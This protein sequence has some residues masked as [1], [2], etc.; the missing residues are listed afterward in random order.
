MAGHNPFTDFIEQRRILGWTGRF[1]EFIEL[2]Y[3]N[4]LRVSMQQWFLVYKMCEVRLSS[5]KAQLLIVISMAVF[6]IERFGYGLNGQVVRGYICEKG[7]RCNFET[8]SV[9]QQGAEENG[10]KGMK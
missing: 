7:R 9:A 8:R 10:P 1:F 4:S 5:L 2:R 6:K 3:R